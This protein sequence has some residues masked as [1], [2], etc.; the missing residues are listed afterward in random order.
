MERQAGLDLVNAVEAVRYDPKR[1]PIPEH[2]VKSIVTSGR[3]LTRDDI[4]RFGRPMGVSK[5]LE[6]VEKQYP[7]K[8][9]GDDLEKRYYEARKAWLLGKRLLTAFDL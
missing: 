4:N 5:A 8:F 2:R 1:L 6:V 7:D 3:Q 9:K